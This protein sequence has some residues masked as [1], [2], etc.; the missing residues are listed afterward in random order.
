[1]IV[2]LFVAI[3]AASR[4]SQSIASAAGV[5]RG[6]SHRRSII[7]S[8]RLVWEDRSMASGAADGENG[9][10][11]EGGYGSPAAAAIVRS[12]FPS[13]RFKFSNLLE[14]LGANDVIVLD[15]DSLLLEC[16]SSAR[17]DWRSGGAFLQVFAAI[18]HLLA[19]INHANAAQLRFV[20]VFFDCNAAVQPDAAARLARALLVRWLSG[21]LGLEVQTFS[22]WWT[23]DWQEWLGR[24]LPALFILS[25]H[26]QAVV[27]GLAGD[28]LAA[29]NGHSASEPAAAITTQRFMQAFLLSS[30][31]AQEGMQCAL[32]PAMRFSEQFVFAFRTM[33][34]S[35]SVKQQ[36]VVAAA[37]T[38]GQGFVEQAAAQQRDSNGAFAV[39]LAALKEALMRPSTLAALNSVPPGKHIVKQCFCCY[40]E[41]DS[42]FSNL[43][44]GA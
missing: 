7:A 20:V 22:S 12:V 38:V 41:E 11:G 19:G 26:P 34:R 3:G 29:G 31:Q 24:T 42:P 1:V 5:H 36:D 27:P 25:D 13:L 9:S 10:S 23:A 2:C 44:R 33:W 15:G 43:G 4:L 8:R 39:D 35:G 21:R 37:C 30:A 6:A 28:E 40:V 32:L 16:L 18:E 14:D 17:L